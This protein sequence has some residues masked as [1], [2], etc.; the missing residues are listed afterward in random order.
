[1]CQRQSFQK[2]GRAGGGSVA[3]PPTRLSGILMMWKWS[4]PHHFDPEI[5]VNKTH[6]VPWAQCSLSM[7][8]PYTQL[9]KLIMRCQASPK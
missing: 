5:K 6:S 9:I 8:D 7:C 2:S 1:M 4:I 3:E